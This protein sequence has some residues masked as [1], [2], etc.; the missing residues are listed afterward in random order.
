LG[1]ISLKV[2]PLNVKS[3]G[4]EI[5]KCGPMSFTAN[6]KSVMKRSSSGR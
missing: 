2:L 5:K 4:K 6:Y 1:L 3:E